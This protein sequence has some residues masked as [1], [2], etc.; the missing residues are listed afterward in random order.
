MAVGLWWL[1]LDGAV[2]T[3]S[4]DQLGPTAGRVAGVHEGAVAL[5]AFQPLP[6]LTVPHAHCLVCAG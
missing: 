6:R 1:Y 3:A 2:V 4:A 5:Q